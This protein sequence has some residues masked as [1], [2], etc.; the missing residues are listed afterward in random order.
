MHRFI[1][2]ALL[3]LAL[4]AWAADTNVYPYT[5]SDQT[6]TDDY[7]TPAAYTPSEPTEISAR[8]QTVGAAAL[9]QTSG[10]GDGYCD[11]D[12]RIATGAQT[13][14]VTF[15]PFK[16]PTGARG[17]YVFLDVVSTTGTVQIGALIRKPHNGEYRNISNTAA[18]GVGDV[19]EIW[20][21]GSIYS[22][23]NTHEQDNIPMPA[24]YYIS[25]L[26]STG[27]DHVYEI[28]QVPFY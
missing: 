8:G 28:S 14:N 22:A 18:T 17:V 26:D 15:G 9:V 16:L 2:A 5:V 7:D 21:A 27:T 6:C 10:S 4:P 19:M 3:L 13:T 24:E 12:S 11:N 23:S 20:G 1:L 25:V